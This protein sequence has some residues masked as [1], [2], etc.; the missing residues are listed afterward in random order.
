MLQRKKLIIYGAVGILILAGLGFLAY[1]FLLPAAT[2]RGGS[3]EESGVA[4]KLPSPLGGRAPEPGTSPAG[5]ESVEFEI[6]KTLE[7]KLFRLTDFPVIGASFNAK[8]DKILFYKKDGGD[9]LS[10]APNGQ[11]QEKISNLT[12]VGITEAL[13]SPARDRAAVFYLDGETLKGFL[14]IGTS[15]VATLPQDIKSFAWA[16]DGKTAVYLLTDGEG[17]KLVIV[18]SSGKN[19]QAIAALPVFDGELSA[20]PAG[21]FA[22]ETAPSG[23]AD[24]FLFTF[25][26]TTPLT[27]IVGPLRG[28]MSRWSN[29]GT[30][31]L[32]SLT[33]LAGKNPDL[34]LYDSSGKLLSPLDGIRTIA[35]KCIFAD[36]KEIY[37]AVPKEIPFSALWPDDYLRGEINTSDRIVRIVPDKNEVVSVFEEGNFDVSELAVTKNKDWLMF[38]DRRDG[39]LWSLKLK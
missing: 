17:M 4:G 10:S 35:S 1:Q 20:L 9:L 8:E 12:I 36:A 31:V 11:P 32:V 25:T 19:N 27:K 34:A 30:R 5:E 23:L 16:P 28:L 7:G 26:R 2:E 3:Q 24:G 37:C 33:D 6:P 14:H 13:W 29:D 39:T 38:V 21:K 18:A 22:L 15:S